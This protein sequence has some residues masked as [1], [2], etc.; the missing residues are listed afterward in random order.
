MKKV[1]TVQEFVNAWNLVEGKIKKVY[2][3]SHGN[4]MSLIFKNGEVISA[5]GKNLLNAGYRKVGLYIVWRH[6]V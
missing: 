2:I 4:G 1:N 3:F 5:S 6:E